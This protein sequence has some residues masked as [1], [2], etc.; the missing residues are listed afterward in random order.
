MVLSRSRRTAD[1]HHSN[2]PGK[3]SAWHG[4]TTSWSKIKHPTERFCR[5]AKPESQPCTTP[6]YVGGEQLPR[7]TALSNVRI[8]LL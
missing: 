4:T 6:V 7:T 3:G 2:R 1:G 5:S 8:A